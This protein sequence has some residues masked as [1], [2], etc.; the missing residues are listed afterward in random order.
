MAPTDEGDAGGAGEPAPMDSERLALLRSQIANVE[1]LLRLPG[2]AVSEVEKHVVPA[3][4]RRTVGEPRWASGIAV[5]LAISLQL[6]LPRRF[7]MPPRWLLPTVGGL[8]LVAVLIANPRM[9]GQRSAGL[10]ASSIALIGLIS[11][12]NAISAL[13]LARALIRGTAAED[14]GL[15]LRWGGAIWL[16]NIVIFGL[17]YWELDRGGPAARAEGTRQYPD[18]LFPQMTTLDVSP[19]GWEPLFL[20]YLYVAFTNAT[21]F[22]P[23]DVLPLTRWAKMLMMA[24]SA[25]SAGTVILVVARAVN[26]LR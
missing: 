11:L 1:R 12:E 17:W 16:T 24:Q 22:S 3:W 26:I 8:L 7:T 5:A 15:L 25:I 6:S 23:T 4:R 18:L 21:A 13:R 14:A 9:K 19:E 20:D 10:R 2:R